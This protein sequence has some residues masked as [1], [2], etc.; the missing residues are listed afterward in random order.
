MT[1]EEFQ[2]IAPYDDSQFADKLSGLVHEPGFE[3]AVRYV[4][5]DVDYPAFC[6]QLVNANSQAEFQTK[7]MK[8]FLEMLVMK[9][10]SGLHPRGFEKLKNSGPVTFMTN[11]R[12][13]VLDASFLNLCLL[14]D[15][16]PTSE[17]A[18][19]NNLLIYSW[20]E[21]LVRIN[22]SFIV[23]RNL[24]LTKALEAARQ[25]SGYM[26]YCI[27]VKHESTWIAQREGRAKDSNDLTQ[28]SLIKM[29][30]LAGGGT[31][32]EN[33][34]TLNITPTSISYEF[35]PCDYL[36]ASEYLSRRRDPDFHK[37]EHDDLLSMETGILGF[38]G[39]VYFTVGDCI[40]DRLDALSP[41]LERQELFHAIATIIDNQIHRGYH[42]FP[43]NY[44]AYDYLE[45]SDRFRGC[46]TEDDLTRFR[47]YLDR[48][49][50]KVK[51]EN[52]TE[53]ERQYMK[54]MMLGMYAYPLHNY[55]AAE[56]SSR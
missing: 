7:I 35:D 38:K 25:L 41:E 18:I 52:V 11:H 16:M 12:D 24:K 8:P 48:Q 1:P 50:D 37:S 17:I 14:Q 15:D 43:C 30:A 27:A 39:E 21:D 10:T 46:Y 51:L 47:A 2:D 26:H 23:K 4:M 49:L 20:I 13:I 22:K 54:N 28:E 36:K 6:Q 44:I 9:T 5:P 55:L 29:L 3:H 19:G 40:N 56:E 32:V 31:V 33:I 34:K 42:I 53:E 45:K